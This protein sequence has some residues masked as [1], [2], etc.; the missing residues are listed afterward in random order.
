MRPLTFEFGRAHG[1]KLRLVRNGQACG[2]GFNIEAALEF[3]TAFDQLKKNLALT[4]PGLY[5][6]LKSQITHPVLSHVA[7]ALTGRSWHS[8]VVRIKVLDQLGLD[9]PQVI[10][11]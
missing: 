5:L 4:R 7:R 6:A 2:A 9:L 1:P 3:T 8:G 10:L 11:S